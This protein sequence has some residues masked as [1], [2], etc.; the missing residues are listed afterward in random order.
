MA[1]AAVPYISKIIRDASARMMVEEENIK[2]ELQNRWL[3]FENA[4]RRSERG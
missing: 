2:D 3:S 4:K 1:H